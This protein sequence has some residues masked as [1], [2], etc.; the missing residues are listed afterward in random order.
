MRKSTL[1]TEEQYRK[2]YKKIIR[3]INKNGKVELANN[4]GEAYIINTGRSMRR[5]DIYSLVAQDAGYGHSE[6][7]AARY[8]KKIIREKTV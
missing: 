8:V 4:K 6:Y 3:E 7:T 5:I 2:S 1:T